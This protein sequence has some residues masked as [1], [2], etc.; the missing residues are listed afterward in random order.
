VAVVAGVGDDL[1]GAWFAAGLGDCHPVQYGVD[2][3]S[4]Q[5]RPTQFGDGGGGD[6][7]V[8]RQPNGIRWESSQPQPPPPNLRR[9]K[10]TAG[11]TP[12]STEGWVFT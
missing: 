8:A 2:S 9:I 11:T 6:T 1:A 3:R 12:S 5:A 7:S 10:P 4:Y